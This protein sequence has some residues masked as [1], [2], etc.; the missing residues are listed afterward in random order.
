MPHKTR[1][2][3]RR[4]AQHHTVD[5]ERQ[6]MLDRAAVANPAAELDRQIDGI[7]DCCNRRAV[8][9]AAGEGAVKVHDVQPHEAG[10]CKMASLS[11]RIP[12]E[13]SSACHIAADEAHTGAALEVNR[14]KQEKKKKK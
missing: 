3:Q 10:I 2:A 14:W 4:G 1:I 9:R 5:A 13:D 12:V 6:P 11:R 7:A 8:H